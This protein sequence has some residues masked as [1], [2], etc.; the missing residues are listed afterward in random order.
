MSMVAESLIE[1]RGLQNYFD[2]LCVHK[3]L[4]FS[5]ASKEIIAIID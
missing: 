1:V 2:D 5:I 3:D 4:H